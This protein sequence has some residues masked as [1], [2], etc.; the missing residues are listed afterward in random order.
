MWLELSGEHDSTSGRPAAGCR[1][2]LWLESATA[3][4]RLAAA[5]PPSRARFNECPPH[6]A[7]RKT[8]RKCLV[9]ALVVVLSALASITTPPLVHAAPD[10]KRKPARVTV[11]DL[12]HF[13]Q[14]IEKVRRRPGTRAVFINVWATWCE[15]CRREMPDIL[16]FARDP[17]QRGVRVLLLSADDLQDRHAVSNFL[18]SVG[19]DF[20]SYLKSG[21]SRTFMNA[22]DPGW[23]G[24]IPTS[25]LL[26]PG[27]KR[28]HLW[29]GSLTYEQLVD[30]VE[31]LFPRGQRGGHGKATSGRN[32]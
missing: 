21:D 23:D 20:P 22:I 3:H 10:L 18:T 13:Q 12:A 14:T 27:G 15:P 7:C 5:L 9:A 16:R 32:P 1:T 17:K 6:L 25:W 4:A 29:N 11:T 31:Q 26:D 30:R 24:N 19:V 28:V 8:T 2:D